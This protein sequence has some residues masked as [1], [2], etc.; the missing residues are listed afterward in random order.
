MTSFYD[1]NELKELGFKHIGKNVMLSRKASI[2]GADKISLGDNSRIDDF[3]ILSG[4]VHIGRY[5]HVAAFCGLFAG[6]AAITLKDFSG[7]SSRVNIYAESDDFGG[8]YMAHPTIPLQYRRTERKDVILEEY[9]IIGCGGLVLPGGYLAEGSVLGAQSL[10]KSTLKAWTIY[11]GSPAKEIKKRS[12]ALLAK[13]I[14]L[15]QENDL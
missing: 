9:S 13:A 12:K 3:S 8:D 7:I 5:V 6:K 10:L 1:Q 4:Q 11:A 2:Y 15:K 14:Q